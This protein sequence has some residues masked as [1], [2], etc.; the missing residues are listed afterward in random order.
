MGGRHV[1]APMRDGSR[2]RIDLASE[3]QADAFWTGEYDGYILRRLMAVLKAGAIALDVGANIGF[4]AVAFGQRLRQL[5]GGTVYAFEPIRANF[6]ALQNNVCLNGLDAIIRCQPVALG[7]RQGEV[8]LFSGYQGAL[9]ESNAVILE[10]AGIRNYITDKFRAGAART[11]TAPITTLDA[12][13]AEH[14]IERCD[15]VKLDIEGAELEFLRGGAEFLPRYQ[16]LI[17]G[18]FNPVWMEKLG[19]SFLD[20]AKLVTPWGYRIYRSVGRAG[21]AP[22]ERPLPGLENV[23][24]APLTL[25]DHDLTRLGVRFR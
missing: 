22:V 5:G 21:F 17:F 10:T 1:I 18:E 13:A 8:E 6:A 4:Y 15:L 12:L 2:V 7:A 9:E 25:S 11:E 16:P 20:V 3:M 19:H 24:M 23:L 14:S